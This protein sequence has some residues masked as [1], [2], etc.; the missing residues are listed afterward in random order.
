L[1]NTELRDNDFSYGNL[2]NL[3]YIGS[4]QK[5]TGST[6]PSQLFLRWTTT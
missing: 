1:R 2:K 5:E 4:V 6:I 3:S